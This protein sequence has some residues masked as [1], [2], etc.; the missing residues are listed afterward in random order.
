MTLCAYATLRLFIHQPMPSWTVTA[1]CLLYINSTYSGVQI[2]FPTFNSLDYK[3]R[4]RI[5][6]SYGNS[7]FTFLETTQ[8][9]VP[10]E[11]SEDVFLWTNFSMVQII[12]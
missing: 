12:R 3:H 9:E 5:A 6:E 11:R 8:N 4:R 7:V 2:Y 1:F 10:L